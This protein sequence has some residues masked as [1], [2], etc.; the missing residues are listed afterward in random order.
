LEHLLAQG[1]SFEPNDYMDQSG[2][3]PNGAGDLIALARRNPP[4]LVSRG[5]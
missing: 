1:A 4:N 3:V 5:R 2:A